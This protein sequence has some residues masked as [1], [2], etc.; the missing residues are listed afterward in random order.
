MAKQTKIRDMLIA[1]G[2]FP[3][4]LPP[5]FDSEDLVRCFKGRIVDLESSKFRKRSSSYVR[6]SGTKHDGHRRAYGTVNPIPYFYLCSFISSNWRIFEKKFN[7]SNISLQNVRLA[8]PKEDRAIVVPPLSELKE[9]MSSKLRFSPF[10]LK[11]DITQFF[12]SIYTHTISWVAHG[13]DIAK[14]NQARD[15]NIATFNALDWAVQQCQSSQTRGVTVGPDAFRIIAEYIGCE[16]DRQLYE[17]T[18][19]LIV[20]GVRHVDDFYLGVRSEVDASVVLSHLRD[21]LQTYELQINDSKTKIICGLDAVD[22]IWAQELRGLSLP[23][24]DNKFS[25]ALDK[26]HEIAK[27]VGSHSP[28]KLILR[29]FDVAKCYTQDSWCSIEPMLQ[30]VLWHYG[31]CTDYVCLLLAKRVAIEKEI[32]TKGW[33]EAIAILI[34]RHLSFNQH[35]EMVWLLWVAFVCK[36]S[37]PDDLIVQVSGVHNSH[38][39]ALLIA[40]YEKTKLQLKPP[41]KLGNSLSTTDENWLQHL[42]GKSLGY[43]KAGFSGDFSEEFGHLAGQRLDLINFDKHILSIA[44][45]NRSAISSS[46]YG[47]DA[48]DEGEDLGSNNPLEDAIDF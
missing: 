36:L 12:P 15:S 10:I 9:R 28:V 16:I 17:R 29:R 6:Y 30:R 22:D 33:S 23:I 24:W 14:A 34:K 41:I 40:A 43:T 3:E 39:K 25:Y 13:Y 1:K 48:Q 45:A 37:L 20:G 11:T 2:Y 42:V 5:C 19:N 21:I 47:Y 7:S 26:A 8:R 44:A 46:K 35:H 31:H 27:T 4:V 32:D 18:G 38:I